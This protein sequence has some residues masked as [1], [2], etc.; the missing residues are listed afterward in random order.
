MYVITPPVAFL[1]GAWMTCGLR[2]GNDDVPVLVVLQKRDLGIEH[3]SMPVALIPGKK[4][5][6]LGR[7]KFMRRI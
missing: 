7:K 3:N 2:A 1:D 6:I 4:A 5:V